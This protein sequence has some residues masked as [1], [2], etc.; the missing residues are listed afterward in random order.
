MK[1]S[2]LFIGFMVLGIVTSSLSAKEFDLK[3]NMI[4]MNSQINNL[5]M[6]FILGNEMT[7]KTALE[8]LEKSVEELFNTRKE[9]VNMFPDS[10]MNQRLKA[11]IAFD[12]SKTM[13]N[14]VATIKQAIANKDKSSIA[15]E[16][17]YLSIVK[18]C[19][20][21]HSLARR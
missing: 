17:A 18:A 2:I 8:G 16:E 1:K 21:C 3:I 20:K 19:F 12:S 9:M 15:Q 7:V 11:E 5:Q 13:K 10:M 14:S 4:E 6:G